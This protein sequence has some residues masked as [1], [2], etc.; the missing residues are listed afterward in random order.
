MESVK[1]VWDASASKKLCECATEQVRIGNRPT[2]FLTSTG[3]KG[4]VA[5]FNAKTGRNYEKK[6]LKNRWDDLKA[7]FSAWVFY[8]LKASGLGW[9]DDTQTITT[10]EAQ[11]AEL[12]KI[13][14][15]IRAFRKGPPD[16]LELMYKMF[17][18]AN[19]DGTSS[20]MP[21]VEEM[22]AIEVE[23]D[24]IDVG[25]DEEPVTPTA[26]SPFLKTRPKRPSSTIPCSPSK[27]KKNNLP[28]DFKRFV[29]H[30]ITEGSNGTEASEIAS[31]MEEVAKCGASEMSDDHYIATNCISR[32]N[33]HT[34]DGSNLPATA[35]SYR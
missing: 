27:L 21:G 16:N 26:T 4:L 30:V 31:I 3:Y 9:N 35:G 1:A 33:K 29:D 11:W 13:H 15:P 22:A 14:K 17:E 18:K 2:K 10:D 28:N 5:D 19:V 25:N 7:V 24:T 34:S 12:I 6:Q 20:I 23:E 32:R 8:K